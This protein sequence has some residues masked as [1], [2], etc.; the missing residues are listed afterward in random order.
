MTSRALIKNKTDG[1]PAPDSPEVLR[2]GDPWGVGKT[3]TWREAL[4]AA[5]GR[6]ASVLSDQAPRATASVRTKS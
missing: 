5:M 3:F 2:L 6:P 1:F 4:T